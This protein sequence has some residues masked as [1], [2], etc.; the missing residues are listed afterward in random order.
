MGPCPASERLR[1]P[2]ILDS[3]RQSEL[4]T[5]AAPTVSGHMTI[6]WYPRCE[7]AHMHRFAACIPKSTHTIPKAYIEASRYHADGGRA[8]GTF[9]V[10]RSWDNIHALIFQT[11]PQ[12]CRKQRCFTRVKVGAA[13]LLKWGFN[14]HVTN[15][16]ACCMTTLSVQQ[17]KL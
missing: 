2:P 9:P 5:V 17:T 7:S 1:D 16:S 8:V 15:H 13:H 12:Y 11:R 4:P 3:V 14:L 6:F 10:A